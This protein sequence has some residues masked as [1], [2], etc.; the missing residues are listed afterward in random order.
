MI[1]RAPDLPSVLRPAWTVVDL[2][3]LG[4]NRER[5]RARVEPAGVLAVLKAD[6]Q[7]SF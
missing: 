2:D 7:R 4:R 1:T 3:A 6:A 5:L